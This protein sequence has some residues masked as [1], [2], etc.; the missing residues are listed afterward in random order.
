MFEVALREI[1]ATERIIIHRHTNPDGDAVG[2]QV[3]LKNIIL[4]NYPGKEVYIVGD[5]AR[6]YSFISGSQ[7]DDIPDSAYSGALAVILDTSA[8]SL[9]SDGRYTLADSTLR[10][11]HHISR[12]KIADYEVTDTSFESCAGMIAA[13]AMECK[14]KIDKTTAYALFCG[15]VTDSGRFRYDSTSS[16]TFDAASFLLKQEP[17]LSDIYR[18]LYT[19]DYSNIRLR[20]QFVMKIRFTEHSV[21]YI[22]T[23]KNELAASGADTFTVSRGMV[24]TMADIRGVDIWVNFTE[25]DSGVLCEIRSSKYNINPIAQKYGGGGHAKASGATLTS[26]D[27]AM[28]MLADLDRLSS[29]EKYE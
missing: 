25:T 14:L 1:A 11:D 12:E 23:D 15:I 4:L 13:M 5:A 10:I 21:A 18:N 20:A 24:N 29:G 6:R 26:Y 28:Q 22:Y 16:R 17:D 27:E 7:T 19:D 9:V 8:S 2:S 3:G